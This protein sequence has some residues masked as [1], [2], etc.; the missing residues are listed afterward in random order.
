LAPLLLSTAAANSTGPEQ[1][2]AHPD[3]VIG[4]SNT[5]PQITSLFHKRVDAA[6]SKY[7]N[8]AP[9]KDCEMQLGFVAAQGSKWPSHSKAALQRVDKD[10]GGAWL[11]VECGLF[12]K[13]GPNVDPAMVGKPARALLH[14]TMWTVKKSTSSTSSSSSSTTTATS[15]DSSSTSKLRKKKED[16]GFNFTLL[17]N[18]E[19]TQLE[20]PTSKPFVQ[21]ATYQLDANGW[22]TGE[23][24]GVCLSPMCATCP[25][26]VCYLKLQCACRISSTS[27]LP[28]PVIE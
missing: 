8:T 20:S 26:I 10:L 23:L 18:A 28:R 4:L 11:F 19:A 21:Y 13:E 15:S 3:L 12:D 16:P 17:L 7:N 25:C 14:L 24:R 1:Q 22:P 27:K 5:T 9:L 2:T 6:T